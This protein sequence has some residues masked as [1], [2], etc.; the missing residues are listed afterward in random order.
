MLAHNSKSDEEHTARNIRHS[1]INNYFL[2]SPAVLRVIHP[3]FIYDYQLSTCPSTVRY[4][5]A[6][7]LYWITLTA[8]TP[9]CCALDEETNASHRMCV[10][11]ALLWFED[12]CVS[13]VTVSTVVDLQKRII[14]GQDCGQNER[15]YHVI[16]QST[17]GTHWD[18]C[19]GSLISDRWILTAA[20]CWEQG[21]TTDIYAIVHVRPG[22]REEMKITAAPKIY[23]DKNGTSHDI[24]LLQLPNPTQIQP[25]PFPDCNNRPQVG[26]TVQI[27]GH[28]ATTTGPNNERL[29][30]VSATLQCA[31][32]TVVDCQ[33]LRDCVENDDPQYYESKHY[34]HLFCC[35]EENVDASHGDSGGGV[36]YNGMIYGVISFT[37]NATHACVEAAAM[38]D[39][40]EY[41]EWIESKTGSVFTKKKH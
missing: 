29:D 5:G 15:L 7:E 2:Q 14:G 8:V 22:Q 33:G 27:A 38:M 28:A 17:N 13:G 21:W 11:T 19:G 34:Q 3:F 9:W 24:M 6:V 31:N 16:L 1:A 25:V 26:D 23:T 12:I 41:K 18:L 39:V 37:A 35:Q 20:H 10:I 32:T 36:V 30:N 4:C 40:C